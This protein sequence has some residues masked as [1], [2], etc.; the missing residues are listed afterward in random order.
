MQGPGKSSG[1]GDLARLTTE[2]SQIKIDD[3]EVRATLLRESFED[4]PECAHSS[5][6]ELVLHCPSCDAETL[7]GD[8]FCQECGTVQPAFREKSDYLQEQLKHLVSSKTRIFSIVLLASVFSVFSILALLA[9]AKLPDELER[10]LSANQLNDAIALADKLMVSRFG[11]LNGRDAELYSA[12]FHRRALVFAN[13]HNYKF[14]I[15]D[16]SKVLPSYSKSKEVAQLSSQYGMILFQGNPPKDTGSHESAVKPPINNDQSVDP[17]EA[18]AVR[19]A[20]NLEASAINSSSIHS[21]GAATTRP[22]S[23]STAEK[24]PPAKALAQTE[25]ALSN[26]SQSSKD[27]AAKSDKEEVNSDS[28]ERDMA[29]YNRHLADYFSHRESKGSQTKDP[30]SFSEWVQSGK[31]DF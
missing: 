31:A 30:P 3:C 15:C 28:E 29:L 5:G 11:S 6:A 23:E 18:P 4:E 7:L 16:L 25:S 22:V 13:N 24:S 21:Q 14:A 1:G 20:K 26:K 9:V 27:E 12:A 10:S 2:T 8:R 17:V 19:S